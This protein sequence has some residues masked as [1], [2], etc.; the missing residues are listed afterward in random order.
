[1][2]INWNNISY[3]SLTNDPNIAVKIAQE[4]ERTSWLK[5]PFASFVGKGG[6]RGVRHYDVNICQPYRPR[7]K[8]KLTGDGVDG[9]TDLDANYDNLEILN[10]T[11]YPRVVANAL[12]SEI[13]QYSTMK[14]INFA[15]EASDSLSEWIQD[16]RDRELV[17][18]LSNDFTNA[19]VASNTTGT[20]YADTTSEYSI[21][22]VTKQIQKGDVCNVALLRRAIFMARTGLRYDGTSAYPIKP[23]KSD[24]VTQNGVSYM[25]NSYIILLDSYQAN[26][27]KSDEE[28]KD[29]QKYAGARGDENHLFTG[30]LGMIDGCPVLD[31]NIWSV[32]QVGMLNS[33]I[34][35]ADFKK[36]IHA[37]NHTTLT[38]PSYYTGDNPVS[39][40]ALIGASALVMVG[41]D[42]PQF[43]FNDKE[44][45]GRKIACGVDRIL[46]ISKGRFAL[47]SGALSVFSNQDFATIGIFTS[48]E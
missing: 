4:I 15:K 26:Q 3:D 14:G 45:M 2:A 17:A 37:Q 34:S 9:N 32:M 8:N 41:T 21:A 13:K 31:M 28:W 11:I 30:L 12:R 48:C 16:K 42:K 22:D 20:G 6:D 19:V 44:D 43:Y 5:S 27:L 7:L 36:N 1:M 23:I 46:S 40:G 25:H 35:D 33:N 24:L 38:P 18:A 10:Q 39:I 29:I 47:E